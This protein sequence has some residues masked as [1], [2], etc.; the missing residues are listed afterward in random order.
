MPDPFNFAPTQCRC[1]VIGN[2]VAHSKS[3]EIHQAFAQQFDLPLEYLRLHVEPGGFEQAVDQFAGGGGLG[4][5]ITLPFKEAA[6][7]LCEAQGF[8]L[9]PRAARAQAVNTLHFAPDEKVGDNTDGAGLVR[10]LEGRLDFALAGRSI[11]L[12]GAGGAA[13]GCLPALI[14]CA[15]AKIAIANRTPERAESLAAAF[16]DAN[17][18]PEVMDLEHPGTTAYDLIINA[19]AASL[20][21]APPALPDACLHQSS[22]LY[23][24]MYAD[25]PTPFLRLAAEHHLRG[26]DGL[27]MLIEQAAES[28]NL[29]HDLQPDTGPVYRHLRRRNGEG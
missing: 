28:F 1:A 12:L 13:R 25:Q 5:N 29:W 6:W 10:D 23:D 21:G 8:N 22:L 17:P 19:T 24:L 9:T 26:E 18:A 15:P 2:P 3:P 27:G 20:S 4:L 16:A 7:R 11:L 14:D